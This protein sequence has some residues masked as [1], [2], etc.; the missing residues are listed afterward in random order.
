MKYATSRLSTLYFLQ[1]AVWGCY[2]TCLGQLL[3]NCG[4]GQYISWFYAA[5]G[6][7]SLIFPALLGSVADRIAN[8]RMMLAGCHAVAALAMLSLWRY[9]SLAERP[10]FLP[11][12]CVYFIFL[13]AYM[14]SLALCNATTFGLL[15]AAGK[16]PVDAFPRIRVWGTIGF[17]AAMWFVNSAYFHDG[18]FSFTLDEANPV[19]RFRFQYT[20]MQLFS[21][22]ATGIVTSLFALTLPKGGRTKVQAGSFDRESLSLFRL[23]DVRIFLLLAMLGGVC[24]QITNGFAVP[25]INHFMAYPEYADSLA[26]GNA[27]MLFSLSQI[28]EAVCVL[29]VGYALRRFGIRI[30]MFI[31]LIAWGLRYLLFAFGN[32]GDG[33]W[34]LVA[35]ML[36]YGVAFNF[37]T[38]AGHLYMQQKSG[39][40]R[41]ALGQGLMMMMSNGLGA[42]IG[43]LGAGAIVNSFCRWQPVVAADGAMRMLFLGDWQ[44]PWLIFAAYAFLLAILYLIFLRPRKA[45]PLS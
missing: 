28:A 36:V 21:A 6:V 27:T 38:I 1:F 39:P 44:A 37:F 40:G 45:N 3:G 41:Q 9:L 8:P 23:R 17:I 18:V 31:A 25:F 11:V 13:A 42:S 33:L 35:S 10:A 15:S 32:P 14:P 29:F 19:A 30:V 16:N 4:L 43:I 2:L 34:M 5:V 20:P 26:A 24:L 22:A 7:V 12:F